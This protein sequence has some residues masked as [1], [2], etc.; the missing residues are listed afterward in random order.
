MVVVIDKNT[1]KDDLHQAIS[2]LRKHPQ[3]GLRKFYGKLKR[4]I[5]GLDYQKKIRNEWD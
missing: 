5:D 4:D 1:S 2:R 3:K